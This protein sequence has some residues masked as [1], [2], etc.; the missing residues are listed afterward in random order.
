MATEPNIEQ[1]GNAA[2]S[3]SSNNPAVGRVVDVPDGLRRLGKIETR[4]RVLGNV[5]AGIALASI[6]F[7]AVDGV[8]V[9]SQLRDNTYFALIACPFFGLAILIIWEGLKKE[10][11]VLVEEISDELE[12]D[13]QKRRQSVEAPSN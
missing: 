7:I 2:P 6:I 9:R 5:I 4:L 11:L 13:Y 10:G 1:S 12:W 3:P 8:L